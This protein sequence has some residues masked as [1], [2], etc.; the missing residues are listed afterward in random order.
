MSPRLVIGAY[1]LGRRAGEGAARYYPALTWRPGL[2]ISSVSQPLLEEERRLGDD[3]E[4]LR[5]RR[6]RKVRGCTKYLV[7]RVAVIRESRPPGP[8]WSLTHSLPAQERRTRKARELLDSIAAL[9]ATL[10]LD[11]GFS[12]FRAAALARE[13]TP[14]GEVF[15]AQVRPDP[16]AACRLPWA[17]APRSPSGRAP[18]G[19]SRAAARR[20]RAGS[21]AARSRSAC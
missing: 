19:A 4:A 7:S 12:V 17:R 14:D 16:R 8:C 9:K 2:Q 1:D 5:D 15:P 13:G 20:R 18:A 11:S 21:R 10:P 3:T 6:I